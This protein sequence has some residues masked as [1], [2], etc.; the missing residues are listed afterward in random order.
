MVNRTKIE[1]DVKEFYSQ[2][3]AYQFKH[4][5]V[6]VRAGD[7]PQDLFFIIQGKVNQIDIAP[8]GNEVVV[9]VFAKP[10]FLSIFW[11]FGAT[12]NRFTYKAMTTVKIHRVPRADFQ[13][14]M[15]TNPEV[16]FMTFQRVIRG[17]DGFM[18]R[19]AIQLYGTAEKKIAVELLLDAK[20]FHKL[21]DMNIALDANLNELTARTGLARETVSRQIACLIR[22]GLVV[23][24]NNK[25][26]IADLSKLEAFMT[27]E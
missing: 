26:V 23:K 22:R 4:D 17:L 21:D 27:S 2:Y 13:K 14:F 25:I 20:R 5:S 1:A 7:I 8:S 15:L 3:P 16:T 9:N 19:M 12:E 18:M 6:I 10:S 11:L 24:A